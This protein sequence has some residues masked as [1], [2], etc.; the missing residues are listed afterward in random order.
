MIGVILAN[1]SALVFAI[2]AS[3]EGDL[4][5]LP[6]ELYPLGHTIVAMDAYVIRQ[7]LWKAAGK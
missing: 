2:S 1:I 5:K 3:P 6:R 4:N 7:L